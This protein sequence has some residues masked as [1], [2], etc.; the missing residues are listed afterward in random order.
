MVQIFDIYKKKT[1]DISDLGK[2]I[3]S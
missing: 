2:N 1:I 3:G